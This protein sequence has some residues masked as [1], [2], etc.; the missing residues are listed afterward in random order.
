VLPAPALGG[1]AVGS[2]LAPAL[3]NGGL[4]GGAL[5]A[6]VG[7]GSPAPTDPDSATGLTERQE[8]SLL[9][10]LLGAG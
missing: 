9:R 8:R 6:V 3:G 5:D 7:G 1:A 2:L 10:Y 4:L